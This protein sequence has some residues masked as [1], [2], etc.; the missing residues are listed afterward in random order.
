MAL[1]HPPAVLDTLLI[2]EPGNI[3]PDR[4]P[5]FRLAIEKFQHLAIGRDGFHHP[6]EGRR[7]DPGL[8]GL[9]ANLA[10]TGAIIRLRH[11]GHGCGNREDGGKRESAEGGADDAHA[12]RIPKPGKQIV[13]AAAETVRPHRLIRISPT[14]QNRPARR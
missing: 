8:L 13:D 6:V 7:I 12:G 14:G 5:E 3:V 1:H 4:G 2:D 9:A 10:E 11:G